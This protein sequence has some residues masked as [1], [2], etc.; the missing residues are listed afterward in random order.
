MSQRLAPLGAITERT[1]PSDRNRYEFERIYTLVGDLHGGGERTCLD[2]GCGSGYGSRQLSARFGSVVGI[3]IDADS[4]R[5]CEGMFSAPN[6]A[7]SVFDPSEQPFPDESFDCVFSFQVLEHVPPA[8]APSYVRHV[9]NMLKPGGAAVVTTP[10]AANYFG[11]HSGNP[12]HL[13]E[14]SRRELAALIRE[15]LPDVPARIAAQEDVLSTRTGIRIRR[16]LHNQHYAMWLARLIVGPLRM[17]ERRGL[18]S[19][20]P[21][22][23]LREGQIDK[24]IGGFY[25]ELR[26]PAGA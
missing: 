2:Y 18:V 13:K 10:N 11:G 5:E 20:D 12:Y 6:L 15:A 21:H 19:I 24:V 17:L 4:I 16:A 3:D 14:Y 8:D 23:M 7:F 1:L 25:V 26:K 22:R 9:W